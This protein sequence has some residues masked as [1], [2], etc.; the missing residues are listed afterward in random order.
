MLP[1]L[2]LDKGTI[3]PIPAGA[4]VLVDAPNRVGIFVAAGAGV[5]S[6]LQ[7]SDG[8]AF[9]GFSAM[10]AISRNLLVLAPTNRR[11]LPLAESIRDGMTSKTHFESILG[12]RLVLDETVRARADYLA[13]LSFDPWHASNNMR[14]PVGEWYFTLDP[15]PEVANY[16]MVLDTNLGGTNGPRARGATSRWSIEPDHFRPPDAGFYGLGRRLLFEVIHPQPG[17][18]LRISLSRSLMGEGRTALPAHAAVDGVPIPMEGNGA[19]QVTS[20]VFPFVEFKGRYYC[21]LDMGEDGKPFA[22]RKTGLMRWMHPEIPYDRRP[23]VAFARDI[24]L[25]T[26]QPEPGP[27]ELAVWPQDLL[28]TEFSGFYEDGWVSQHAFVRMAAAHP[29]DVLTVEGSVPGIG[30]LKAGSMTVAIGGTSSIKPI[31][32][33]FFTFKIPI[34]HEIPVADVRL[35][36]LN[37]AEL[38]GGDGRPVS[39]H[40]TRIGLDRR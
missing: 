36:F 6:D 7:F 12:H 27:R 34:D 29:G 9:L 30:N 22:F 21:A 14:R 19:A 5:G 40:I 13:H 16:L 10:N 25:I 17:S 1:G 20:D 8:E 28:T 3:P 39:A 32:A 33:S 18:R 38:P 11:D 24:S 15:I 31:T 35:D 2:P 23:L 37:S 26:N 4:H